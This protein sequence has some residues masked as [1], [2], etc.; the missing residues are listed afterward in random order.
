MGLVGKEAP[1]SPPDS[2]DWDKLESGQQAETARKMAIYAAQVERLDWNMGRVVDLMKQRGVFENTV[3]FFLSDNGASAEGGQLGG[4]F[5]PD[6][7]GP[8]GSVD[9]YRSYGQSW[10]NVSNTPFRRHKTWVREGGISSPFVAHWPAGLK[11]RPGA[12][13]RAV[14]HIIDVMPTVCELTGAD[15]PKEF[16]GHAIQPP[17]GSSLARILRGETEGWSRT[18]YWEHVRNAAIRDGDWKLVR[19]KN[20]SCGPSPAPRRPRLNPHLTRSK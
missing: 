9:S 8:I 15:Y 11:S 12:I 2:V 17:A 10:A 18:L 1:L 16:K 5:R 7:K 3:I 6:F 20:D 19:V 14:A 13:T 4:D